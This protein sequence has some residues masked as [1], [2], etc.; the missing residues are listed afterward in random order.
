MNSHYLFLTI[1]GFGVDP[2]KILECLRTEFPE[3]DIS[4]SDEEFQKVR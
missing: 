4:L 1:H 3:W 2:E